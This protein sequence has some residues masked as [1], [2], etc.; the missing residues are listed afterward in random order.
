MFAV[1]YQSF[2]KPGSESQYQQSWKQVA[3][4]FIENCSAIGSALHKTDEGMWLAYSRWPDKATRDASW[5][6]GD[7][8]TEK[9]PPEIIRAIVTLKECLDPDR[10]FP[11]ITMTVIDDLLT[12][13][14][15]D[16]MHR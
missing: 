8:I 9:F 7:L 14:K 16:D 5:P 4:Y 2:L 10:K 11:D 15:A 6:S 1:I 13:S 12:P 3:E